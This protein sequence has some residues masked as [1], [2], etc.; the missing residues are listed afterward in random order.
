MGIGYV[1]AYESEEAQ[2]GSRVVAYGGFQLKKGTN[3]E[4]E[5]RAL[6]EGLRHALRLGAWD[7]S[8]LSDSLLVVKQVQGYWKLK[9]GRLRVQHTEV[10]GLLAMFNT[11]HIRHIPREEN[12]RADELS[13]SVCLVE[14]IF[15]PLPT[16][17][18][19]S[20]SPRLLHD[21]QAAF[22]RVQ[23]LRGK[24]NT[25]RLARIFQV[26][27]GSV[28]GIGN[29]TSYRNAT[30]ASKPDLLSLPSS[31]GNNPI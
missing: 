2:G 3:N 22:V 6:V 11:W 4:A 25:Y 21:W 17:G 28:E 12:E 18:V 14:P 27:E 9:Q 30:F 26:S 19:G 23:W 15:P 16:V 10:M 13:H 7:I 24:T 1:L 8:I 20:R 31:H 5:Y 29:G